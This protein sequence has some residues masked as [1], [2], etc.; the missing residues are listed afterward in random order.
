MTDGYE[1]GAVTLNQRFYCETKLY[2][3]DKGFF[4]LRG[5]DLNYFSFG[6]KKSVKAFYGMF[7]VNVDNL[8][9]R[10]Q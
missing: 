8:K 9:V 4:G 6:T 5:H 3:K 2:F 10:Y 7:Q 1:T